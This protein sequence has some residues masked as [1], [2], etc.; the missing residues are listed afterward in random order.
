MSD[1]ELQKLN[2]DLDSGRAAVLVMCDANEV[3]ATSDYLASAGGRPQGHVI[4]AAELE[5]A[6]KASEGQGGT[7]SAGG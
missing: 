5:N 7:Q 3:R 4:D 6:P 2:E 1:E